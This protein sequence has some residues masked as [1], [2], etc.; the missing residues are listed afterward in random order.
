MILEIDARSF[1]VFRGED[2]KYSTIKI[3]S[4]DVRTSQE[5]LEHILIFLMERYPRE[6]IITQLKNLGLTREE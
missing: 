6:Q 2:P 4:T 3:V 5:D 1:S